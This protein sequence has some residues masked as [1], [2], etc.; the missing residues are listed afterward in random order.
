MVAVQRVMTDKPDDKQ[1]QRMS[2]QDMAGF[3]PLQSD[4]HWI[5][6]HSRYLELFGYL[7]NYFYIEGNLKIEVYQDRKNTKERFK[8]V[9]WKSYSIFQQL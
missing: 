4:C 7:R 2:L 6:G 5:S 1:S 3:F 9:I 8:A